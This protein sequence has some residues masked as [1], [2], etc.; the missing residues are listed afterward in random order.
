MAELTTVTIQHL[1]TEEVLLRVKIAT[2]ILTEDLAALPQRETITVTAIATRLETTHL[3][4][5]VL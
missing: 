2:T 1:Q 4:H 3:A 5:L